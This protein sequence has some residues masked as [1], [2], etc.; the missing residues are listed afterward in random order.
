MIINPILSDE[1]T[2]DYIATLSQ[3]VFQMPANCT[4]YGYV[5][6]GSVD[7]PFGNSNRV[8]FAGEFFSTYSADR[9][10][11]NVFGTAVVIARFGWRGHTVIGVADKDGPGHVQYIDGCTDSLVIAPP[12]LGDP[13]LN[14][15]YFPPHVDQTFHTHPSY[16]AGVVI[17]GHGKASLDDQEIDLTTGVTFFL[18]AES[19]HRF[20]TGDTP[21]TVLAFHPDSDWGPTDENHPMLNRTIKAE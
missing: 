14:L 15:L 20:R 8:V 18:P 3:E 6:E 21:M 2:D 1:L 7:V 4:V 16:R 10:D 13:C 9:S 11:I 12:R 17:S 5:L 19:R